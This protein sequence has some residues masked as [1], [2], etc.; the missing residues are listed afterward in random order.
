M[1]VPVRPVSVSTVTAEITARADGTMLL[2]APGGLASYPGRVT[3]WLEHWAARAPGRSF[4]AERDGDGWRHLTYGE[5]LQRVLCCSQALLDRELSAERPVVILSGNSIDHAVLTLACLHVGIACAPLSPAYS[6]AGGSFHKLTHCLDLL[7][8]GLVFAADGE[9]FGPALEVVGDVEAVTDMAVL[10]TPPTPAVDKAAAEVGPDTVAKLLFT[11]GSTSKPKAVITT[12]RMLCSNQ[13]MLRQAFPVLEAEPPVLADWLPWSHVFGG[14]HNLGLVLANGGT[15][16]IDDGLP[17]PGA[18]DRTVRTLQEIAPT[19]YYNVPKGYVELVRALRHDAELRTRF[20]SRVRMLFYA[21]ASLPQPVWDEMDQLAI[22][23]IGHR[24]QWMTGMGM[25]ETAPFAL[26]CR[27]DTALAGTVGLPVHGMELK[28]ARVGSKLEARM[29]GPNITPGY[30]RDPMQ[31]LAAFDE[32]GFFRSG[33]AVDFVDRADLQLGL[34]FD[35]RLTE[36]FK[37]TSG[38]W[39]SV[40]PLRTR[41]VDALS[42]WVRDIVVAGEGRDSLAVLAVTDP[43]SASDPRAIAHIRRVLAGQRGGSASRVRRLGFLTAPLSID[44]GELT[45]KGSINQRVV[46][47]RHAALV[48]RLYED[49]APPCVICVEEAV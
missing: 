18:F 30:W 35:G 46:L 13:Q 37:L 7:T 27:P 16:Y 26:T 28:L 48:A 6:L 38:T 45:D 11:S 12:H 22:A 9:R 49:P 42:P 5:A 36:D 29:R 34:R 21:A 24:I 15:L 17:M 2:R 43:A 23:T 40:G 47:A 1:H 41:L 19:L 39:V 33:D 14:N 25:T 44:S 31:T 8:P 32:E 10:M 4:L 20:F 3:H